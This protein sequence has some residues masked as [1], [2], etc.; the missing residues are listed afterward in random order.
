LE[1]DDG[2]DRESGRIKFLIVVILLVAIVVL[3]V[4]FVPCAC[5]E[6]RTSDE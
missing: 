3:A 6:K 1:L 2:D 5:T 4:V